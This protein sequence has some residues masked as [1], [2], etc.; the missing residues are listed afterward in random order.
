MKKENNRLKNSSY[1][2]VR[3]EISSSPGTRVL[4]NITKLVLPQT[5][6]QG[7][8][9][10]YLKVFPGMHAFILY[11]KLFSEWVRSTKNDFEEFNFIEQYRT[12]SI[13]NVK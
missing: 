5:P 4:L 2:G 8:D 7:C 12:V 11:L 6:S 10:N 3:W 9:K 1:H 13:G